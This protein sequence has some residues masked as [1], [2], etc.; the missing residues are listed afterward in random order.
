MTYTF[1]LKKY[2]H[3]YNHLLT[4][5]GGK[6]IYSAVVESAPT[7]DETILVWLED[8]DF[9]KEE[10]NDIKEQMTQW[11]NNQHMKCTFVSGKGR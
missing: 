3:M 5:S 7:K 2:I 9:P 11:F 1:T 6:H 4:V 8:F 10:V